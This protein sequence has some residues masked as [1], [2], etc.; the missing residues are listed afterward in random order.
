MKD[1]K[2]LICESCGAEMYR[3]PGAR[4]C[5]ECVSR[6]Q[7]EYSKKVNDRKYNVERKLARGC[8]FCGVKDR[9]ILE[10]H[11]IDKDKTNNERRNLEVLCR[12]CHRK[13]HSHIYKVIQ[14]TKVAKTKQKND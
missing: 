7:K 2:K 12:S 10:V 1:N 4:F 5:F 8:L 3:A 13:L 11:H 9:K 14:I 6:K